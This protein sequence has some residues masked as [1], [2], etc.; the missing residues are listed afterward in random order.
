[1]LV[2]T[3]INHIEVSNIH[4]LHL[5]ILKINRIH[6]LLRIIVT[7]ELNTGMSSLLTNVK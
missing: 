4:F 1:M 7:I 6:G 3:L 2:I 5:K